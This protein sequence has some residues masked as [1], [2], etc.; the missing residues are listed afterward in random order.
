MDA[1]RHLL[2]E[3]PSPTEIDRDLGGSRGT[4]YKAKYTSDEHDT[5]GSGP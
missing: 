1:T 4:V 3:G 2:A 5:R